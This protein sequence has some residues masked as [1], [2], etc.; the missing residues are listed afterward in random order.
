MPSATRKS[1]DDTGGVSLLGGDN[2]LVKDLV[3]S[4]TMR[5]L[6]VQPIVAGISSLTTIAVFLGYFGVA[7]FTDTS[8]AFTTW[9]STF[10]PWVIG[11]TDVVLFGVCAV[12]MILTVQLWRS[13]RA[14]NTSAGKAWRKLH[15]VDGASVAFLL[16]IAAF[17]GL[18]LAVLAYLLWGEMISP[19]GSQAAAAVLTIVAFVQLIGIS[20]FVHLWAHYVHNATCAAK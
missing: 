2:T 3:D 14:N 12:L 5:L 18:K 13:H 20:S 19:W 16:S 9:Q 4:R 8:S 6:R 17:I 10:V 15:Y 11:V 7:Q 1:D